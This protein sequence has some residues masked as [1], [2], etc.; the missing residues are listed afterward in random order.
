V[1]NE[2]QIGRAFDAP[3]VRPNRVRCV[4]CGMPVRGTLTECWSCGLTA[5]DEDAVAAPVERPSEQAPAPT[6]VARLAI[7][8]VGAVLAVA[9]VLVAVSV[10]VPTERTATLR[11]L[12][13]RASGDEWHQVATPSF[14]VDL[15]GRAVKVSWPPGP[16][17]PEAG[18]GWR[19]SGRGMI[20]IV[21]VAPL[22]GPAT[23][24]DGEAGAR[25]LVKGLADERHATLG[26]VQAVTML[27]AVGV[28]ATV[29]IP[30]AAVSHVRAVLLSGSAYLLTLE[31][32]RADF[33]RMVASFRLGAS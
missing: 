3:P 4:H 14:S 19:A 11:R 18:Q 33:D 32:A 24:I 27:G 8:G 23:T 1:K 29:T 5:L 12:V 17:H 16:G 6:R 30:G 7:A 2:S 15:P 20:A 26:A 21:D 10:L 22:P 28:D 31:G 9:L 25:T 13:D